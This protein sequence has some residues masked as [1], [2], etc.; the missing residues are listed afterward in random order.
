MKYVTN[1][2]ES[3][4][5][6]LIDYVKNN[7]GTVKPNKEVEDYQMETYLKWKDAGINIDKLEWEFFSEIPNVD[8]N[9][10]FDGK[11]VNWWVSKLKPGDMF[12]MHTDTFKENLDMKRYWVACED[13]QPGHVFM[14]GTETL[15]NYKAG[16]VF[17][18]EPN[19][20]HGACN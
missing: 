18:L 9:L 20:W 16:D 19:V 14:Y 1:I 6:E 7:R 5:Q 17:E 12:P 10:P 8:L 13:H 4:P 15:N 3:I 2:K 11:Q